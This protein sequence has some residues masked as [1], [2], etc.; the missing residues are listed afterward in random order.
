MALIKD[1]YS[2]AFYQYLGAKL[3]PYIPGFHMEEFLQLA[4]TP[5]FKHMEWKDRVKHTTQLLHKI[6][7]LDYKDGISIIL[8]LIKDIQA[9]S[10]QTER[11]AYI[12]FPD[13]VSTYGLDHYDIS[14]Q[15]LEQITQFISCEFAVRPF[16]VK[17]EHQM[18]HQMIIWSTHPH[19]KVR[20]LSSEGS[21]PRLPWS[22][23]LDALKK[24]PKPSFTL[25][26]NLMEDP[27]PWVRKSVANHLNDISKDHEDLFIEFIYQWKGKSKYTDAIIK[28]AS[29]TLLKKGHPD[30]LNFYGLDDTGL[31]ISGF[32]VQ[33]KQV[34]IGGALEFSFNLSN[35][36][37]KAKLARIEYGIYYNKANG[38]L[39]RKVFKISERMID[40]NE[41]IAITRKQ[42]FKII[43]TRIFYP[44]I[45]EVSIIIN[46]QELAKDEFTL[47][48]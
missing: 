23:A 15:A 18:H 28:H 40:P 2:L 25:L 12:I 16:L 31:L 10:D 33:H 19:N 17:Y 5:E 30:I 47:I 22:F 9:E 4:I 7:P 44:G 29:R 14:V 37:Q 32:T 48:G 26:H 42:S 46:G 6:L 35:N 13:Y 11:L 21:R 1:I 41:K 38:N 20:R 3:R 39:A 27:D 34:K 43:T 45:H 24:D 8:K 36:L